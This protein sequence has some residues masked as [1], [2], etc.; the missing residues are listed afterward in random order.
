M[1]EYRILHG[2]KLVDFLDWY[3]AKE[4]FGGIP[5]IPCQILVVSNE[6]KDLF[7]IMLFIPKSS[8]CAWVGFPIKNPNTTKEETKGGFDFLIQSATEYLK[9]L[10]F[11]F[12]FS[13]TE[14]PYVKD[15]F[16]NN[17]FKVTDTN[18]DLLIKK[19]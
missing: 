10:S 12:I 5:F 2:K 15:T 18:I 19:I 11:E 1:M 16:L 17:E 13:T 8:N 9:G 7:M 6:D 14:I 4:G 3:E